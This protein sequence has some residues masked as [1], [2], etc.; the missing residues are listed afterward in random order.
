MITSL[1]IQNFQAHKKLE[2][3]LD[4]GIT[5]IVGS[6]DK[7]KSAIIRA[8]RWVV[9]NTP[10]GEEIISY[11]E[12]K[13]RVD[14]WMDKNFVSRIRGD[15]KNSYGIGIKVFEAFGQSVPREIS[16]AFNLSDINF[17][18]QHDAPFW[19]S[20]S[21]GEVSRRL[22]AIINLGSIDKIQAWI[23]SAIRDNSSTISVIES[24]LEKA[25][26]DRSRLKY[27]RDMD[28]KLHV[29]EEDF[30]DIERTKDLATVLRKLTGEGL[31]LVGRV[32]TARKATTAGEEAVQSGM[33]WEQLEVDRILLQE[34]ILM[35]RK[36]ELQ[37]KRVIPDIKPLERTVKSW[38]ALLE[39]VRKVQQQTQAVTALQKELRSTT[40]QFEKEMGS[41]CPLCKQPIHKLP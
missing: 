31:G 32:Q 21:S 17:Q 7:G 34:W 23:A 33:A 16:E 24:R 11:G 15:G 12:K 5:T 9:T 38:N 6:S 36:L 40:Q 8:L 30:H 39:L 3:D 25:R 19:F 10:A 29:L 20:E 41:V 13:T 4:P 28:S 18:N 1:S 14:V 27:V 22:N 26:E 2:I 35:A 37:S